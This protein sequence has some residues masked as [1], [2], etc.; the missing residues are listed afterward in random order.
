MRAPYTEIEVL[1]VESLGHEDYTFHIRCRARAFNLNDPE[2]TPAASILDA[3][4]SVRDK[5]G[6]FFTEGEP[7]AGYVFGE[8]EITEWMSAHEGKFD[9]TAF[10]RDSVPKLG[11]QQ[12]G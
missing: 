7:L 6:L 9:I 10:L 12:R 1:R 11:M 2:T 8:S 4:V 5:F 3:A